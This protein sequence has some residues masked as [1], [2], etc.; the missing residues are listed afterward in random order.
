MSYLRKAS[1]EDEEDLS[2]PGLLASAVPEEVVGGCGFPR[3]RVE[4]RREVVAVVMI[5]GHPRYSCLSE[6]QRVG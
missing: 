4:R 5:A 6:K 3:V 1:E 2:G